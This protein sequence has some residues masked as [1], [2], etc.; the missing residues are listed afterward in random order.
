MIH[1][2]DVV[3]SY[4]KNPLFSG[5]QL[6]LAKGGVYGLLGRNGAG[7]TSLL[8]LMCGLLAPQEG[9]VRVCNQNPSLRRRELLEDIFFLPE[10]FSL[11]PIP[12][13]EYVQAHS[14]FYPRFDHELFARLLNE[15]SVS[16]DSNIASFS[17]GQRKKAI[18]SFALASGCRLV[19]LDE[20]TNSLDIP[21]RGQFRNAVASVSNTDRVIILSTHQVK[22]VENLIDAV[23]LLEEGK[24]ILHAESQAIIKSLSFGTTEKLP[25]DGSVVYSEPSP[26][27]IRYVR[28]RFAGQTGEGQPGSDRIDWE[29]VFQAA[30]SRPDYFVS[31][32]NS[33]N[34]AGQ[35]GAS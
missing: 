18:V 31:L 21:S 6:D 27:G 23:V 13:P 20:P 35:G 12:L 17:F 19:V 15:F 10:E 5:L 2:H 16:Y 30:I 4:N 1:L 8:R 3:F 14:V 24:I 7:K 22:D 25:D 34:T 11:P 33:V 26:D 32:L 29:L 9:D 28:Q